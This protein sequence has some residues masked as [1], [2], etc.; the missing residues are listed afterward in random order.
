MVNVR[1][2]SAPRKVLRRIAQLLRFSGLRCCYAA[3][4][5]PIAVPRAVR[6]KKGRCEFVKPSR[7]IPRAAES[8]SDHHVTGHVAVMFA[9][10]PDIQFDESNDTPTV[11]F[12][13]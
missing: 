8:V 1:N 2:F 13:A 7:L 12:S 11:I 4:R 3:G 6:F 9:K 5:Y 10:I